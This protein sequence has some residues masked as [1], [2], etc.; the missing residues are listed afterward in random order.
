MRPMLLERTGKIL[1]NQTVANYISRFNYSFKRVSFIALAAIQENLLN[2]RIEFANW[3]LEQ[4][5]NRRVI[6]F[7]D[8][9]GF[10]YCARVSCGRSEKGSKEV[11]VTPGIQS[12]HIS[13]IAGITNETTKCSKF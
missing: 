5:G 13:V 10:Q 12:K 4:H 9:V 8:E 1:T 11:V 6:I 2:Q 7:V 3:I